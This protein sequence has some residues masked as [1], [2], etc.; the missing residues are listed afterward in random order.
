M[1]QLRLINVNTTAYMCEDFL[2]VTDL[3]DEQITEVIKPLV[4]A[5]RNDMGE[6]DNE[7]LCKALR[8]EYPNNVV[9]DYDLNSTNIISI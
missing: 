9:I 1:K 3:T 6:Y 8:D 5:E 2:L 4:Y 7:S